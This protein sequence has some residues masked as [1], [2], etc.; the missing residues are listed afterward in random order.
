MYRFAFSTNAFRRY[1]LTHALL[2]IARCGYEGVEILGDVPHAYPPQ[3]DD[4]K[5]ARIR[6]ALAE[7]G[8]APANVNAFMLYGVQNEIQHPSWI[9][10]DEDFRRLRFQHTI[11]CLHLAAKLGA[12]SIQTQPGGPL[13]P[14]MTREQALDIFEAGIRN[15]LAVA[16]DTGVKLLI[17]PEPLLLIENVEQ[18]DEFFSRFDS[19]MLGLNFDVGHFYCVDEDVPAAV[20]HFGDMIQ[21]VHI[22]DIAADRTHYHMVPGEGAIE[23]SPVLKSLETIGYG[24]FVTVELY[25]HQESPEEAARKAL[26]RLMEFR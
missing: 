7:T 25:M 16:E 22:E 15:A 5:I 26:Q 2:A 13:D 9:E 21:H 4:R 1:E 14:S 6:K 24:G 12:P 10:P 18:T 19:P 20:L 11:D 17:E 8:L 3:T 23:F